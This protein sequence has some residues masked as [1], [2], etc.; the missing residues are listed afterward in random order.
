MDL[1]NITTKQE[2]INNIN[3]VNYELE[4][5]HIDTKQLIFQFTHKTFVISNEVIHKK[6][7]DNQILVQIKSFCEDMYTDLFDWVISIINY[8]LLKFQS[9]NNQSINNQSINNHYIGILDI[10]GFEIFRK[11]GYEQLCIN[12]T[13]EILQQIYNFNILHYE[14]QE[15]I[16]EGL[17]WN[18]I[19]YNSNNDIVK[20]FKKELFPII[21]EQSILDSGDNN[22]I[23]NIICKNLSKKNNLITFNDRYQHKKQFTIS[24]YAGNVDYIVDNYILKN[25][26]KSKNRK[27]KTNLQLFTNQLD[28][29]KKELDKSVCH[30]IRCIKPNDK[31]IHNSFNEVKIHQQLLYSGIIEGIKLILQGFPIKIELQNLD[32][33]F[34]FLKYYGGDI[35][36]ILVNS[37]EYGDKYAIGKSK[38][39]LKKNVYNNLIEIN[40]NNRYFLAT[41]LVSQVRG[42]LIKKSYLNIKKHIIK[43]QSVVRKLFGVKLFH[44]LRRNWSSNII[45]NKI[46]SFFVRKQYKKKYYLVIKLQS[47]YRGLCI[48][49]KVVDIQIRRKIA[50]KIIQNNYNKIINIL[51]IKLEASNRIK[52]CYKWYLTTKR[53]Q[54]RKNVVYLK[55]IIHK[56]EQELLQREEETKQR[57]LDKH[58]ELNKQRELNKHIEFENKLL[59]EKVLMLDEKNKESQIKNNEIDRL[60]KIINDQEI[61]NNIMDNY[62]NSNYYRY[63]EVIA[64]LINMDVSANEIVSKKLEIM[65]LDL[66]NKKDD[67]NSLKGEYTDLLE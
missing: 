57:E 44:K 43:I 2:V 66:N 38:L 19:K 37:S 50:T 26:I 8:Q 22:K 23:Y 10:F 16:E 31:N 6:L 55:N 33:D 54:K 59:K 1:L 27:I 34:R 64:P 62:N 42:W 48:R 4:K 51:I 11:N 63:E 58:R 15:Y 17:E 52:L 40:N 36:N 18:Y 9:I 7:E 47:L 61:N 13:N 67:F 14:Q 41:K 20:L 30:F 28:N 25:R 60:E 56:Q 29:L 65:Y 46:H 49:R 45:T 53:I 35:I 5:L 24:H 12:F 3:N 21:N 39:F 32:W